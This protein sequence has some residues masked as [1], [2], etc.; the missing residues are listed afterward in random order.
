MKKY[1]IMLFLSFIS[2]V[3]ELVGVS[4]LLYTVLAIFEP[5]FIDKFQLTSYLYSTLKIESTQLFI[6]F[7]T[8]GLF[9]L[10]VL[11]NII[12][13]QISKVQ[14]K[15][16]FDINAQITDDYYRDLV[17]KDLIFFN[18]NDSTK[19]LNDIIGATLNFSES[20]LLSSVLFISEW[21]IVTILLG[22]V[23]FL[24]PLLFLFI[25]IVLV[26]TAGLLMYINKKSIEKISKKE[27]ELAPKIYENVNYLTRG[28]SAIKL[29]NSESYFYK[30]Y[31][32][33]R[34]QIYG[35]KRSVYL[36]SNYI[37][38]RTY[39][40]IA[41]AGLLCVII[42]G[43]YMGIQASMIVAYISIYA[44]VSFR[45]LPSVNRIITSSNNLAS[46]N[47]VLDYLI[48]NKSNRGIALR[49]TKMKF[50]RS[51]ELNHMD[52]SY[53]DR[54]PI[55]DSVSLLILK[56]QF[57][58]LVGSSGSGKSTLLHLVSS[59]LNSKKGQL[60]IDGVE[61]DS[62][63]LTDYRYLFSYV[64]QDI[65]M[66]N[67]SILSNIAFSDTNPNLNKINQC[68][69]RVNLIKWI[70][71]LPDGIHTSIG[72]LGGKISGG[73]KQRIAFAR[74]LYKDSE[75]FLFDEIS[76]NLDEESKDEVLKTMRVLKE[77]G[78]TAL[79]VTHN[80]E[81]LAIC[82]V[83]YSIENRKIRKKD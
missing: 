60:K 53:A 14:I 17:G 37:P 6:L 48:S 51:V 30:N 40:V 67:D 44:A 83:V 4:L 76:N 47:H 72:E 59:L 46:R 74:A 41:I 62:S 19:I 75:I 42:Y 77:E 57:I 10:Y 69:K 54:E 7:L 78:K 49:H 13:I 65:F 16:S 22:L 18:T 1:I 26:P 3:L 55:L 15:Y 73:Q 8:G 71:S 29:W 39:E 50:D 5:N 45:I 61:I 64:N 24:Q 28:T 56:G 58:G 23:L 43:I 35:L 68:L 63:N 11:K 70:D 82:D 38:V 36:K 33:V 66:L 12:L 21:F 32:D 27:H 81:E 80:K 20:I 9:L 25:F 31:Q 52:F 2:A 34:D 79:F